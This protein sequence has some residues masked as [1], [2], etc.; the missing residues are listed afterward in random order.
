MKSFGM[1]SPL[2]DYILQERH[3]VVA[4]QITANVFVRTPS[5]PEFQK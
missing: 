3:S 1:A 2:P 4:R 5:A